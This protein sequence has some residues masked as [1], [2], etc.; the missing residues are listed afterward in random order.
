MRGLIKSVKA[1]SLYNKC[2]EFQDMSWNYKADDDLIRR[3]EYTK[4][5]YAQREKLKRLDFELHP[6][7]VL[8]RWWILCPYKKCSTMFMKGKCNMDGMMCPWVLSMKVVKMMGQIWTTIS[9]CS[10]LQAKPE[11]HMQTCILLLCTQ[12][13]WVI[14]ELEYK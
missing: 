5:F 14:V 2:V 9:R 8:S 3:N 13:P 11:K 10:W 4:G 1:S 12:M 6:W 7:D